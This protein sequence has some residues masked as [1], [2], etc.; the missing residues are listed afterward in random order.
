MAAP[1]EVVRVTPQ[2]ED[3]M[4]PNQII[5]EFNRPVVPLGRMDRRAEEIPVEIS[6]HLDCEWR[7]IDS[8]TLACLLSEERKTKNATRYS[9]VMHPGIRAEDGETISSDRSFSF[10]TSRARVSY[11]WFREWRSPGTPTINLVFTDKV[12]R[13]SAESHLYF[14]ANGKRISSE[15]TQP[16]TYSKDLSFICAPREEL[17]TGASVDL[18]IEPGIEVLEGSEL[19]TDDRTIVKFKTFPEFEVLGVRCRTNEND[20][21]VTFFPGD[22][23]SDELC[24]PLS[25]ISL[26]FNSP[27]MKE[28][29]ISGLSL[30]PSPFSKKPEEDPWSSVYTY[31]RRYGPVAES[32]EYSVWL[33]P[34]LRSAQK[35]VVNIDSSKIKD[36]FGRHPKPIK[37]INIATDHRRPR[38]VVPTEVGT[39]ESDVSTHIP[40]AVQNLHSFDLNYG[41]LTPSGS[42][43]RLQ[44]TIAVD[45]VEDLSYYFPLR[46]RDLLGASSG[47][48]FGTISTPEDIRATGPLVP[49]VISQVSPFAIHLKFGHRNSIAW[50]TSFNTG[51]P[52]KGVQISVYRLNA[53]GTLNEMSGE[54]ARG[55]SD[56]SGIAELPG[57]AELDPEL[58]AADYLTECAHSCSTRKSALLFVAKRGEQMGF[59]SSTSDFEIYPSYSNFT[60]YSHIKSWGMTAQGVY[61]LGDTVQF[62]LFVRDEENKTLVPAPTGKYNLKVVDP[63]DVVV[64]EFS[65]ISLSQFG[66]FSSEF[67]VPEKGAVGIYRFKLTADFS[68][69]TWYPFNVLI[70][71]FTP[72]PFKVS[73]IIANPRTVSIGDTVQLDTQASLYAGGPYSNAGARI[74]ARIQAGKFPEL[75]AELLGFDFDLYKSDYLDQNFQSEAKLDSSGN[76]KTTFAVAPSN[77]L[78]GKLRIESAVRDDRGR[79]IATEEV[80]P[81]AGRERY[82]GLRIKDWLLS[83]GKPATIEGVL[84]DRDC[85]PVKGED[86]EINISREQIKAS[87]VK[88]AGNA[89]LTEYVRE[90]VPVRTCKLTSGEHPISCTFIPDSPGQYK[91]LAS[92]KD[93]KGQIHTTDIGRYA[94]GKGEVVWQTDEGNSLDVVP[95]KSN[96][97]VGDTAKFFVKNPFPG[98][99]ALIS[100]ERTG[101]ISKQVRKLPDSASVIEVPVTEDLIPGFYLSIVVHLPRV[102]RPVE[103]DVDL[104]K[105]LARMGYARIEVND[106]IKQLVVS[107]KARKEEYRPK[108][109]V[110]VDLKIGVPKGARSS[111]PTEV[112]IAVVDESVFDLI[113]EG[114]QAYDASH[115]FYKLG[116]LDLRNF[117]DLVALVGRRKF[118]KKGANS[119]GSGGGGGLEDNLR[120]VKKFVAY[121]NPALSIGPEGKTTFSFSAPDNLTSWKVIAIAATSTDRFGLGTSTLKVNQPLEIRAALPNVVR[122]GDRFSAKFT[123]LNR[124]KEK[125]DA[126]V[127]LEASGALGEKAS[128]SMSVEL[129]PFERKEVELPIITKGDGEVLVDVRAQGGGDFHDRF[130]SKIP[131]LKRTTFE[132]AAAYG[133]TVESN[134]DQTIEFPLDIRTDVGSLD[135]VL[136]SSAISSVEGAFKY[137]RDYPYICWEQ[138]LTKAIMAAHFKAL[139]IYLPDSMIWPESEALPASTLE[140]AGSYQT[141]GGGMSFYGGGDEYADPYLSAYTALGFN[142]LRDIGAKVPEEAERKLH[143]YL[144][145]LL[146]ENVAPSFYSTGMASSVRA[147]ALSALASR[148][149]V[150]LSDVERFKSAL[151][152]MKLFGKA[153]YLQALA[154]LGGDTSDVTKQLLASGNET[155]GKFVFSEILA[156]EDS[157]ILESPLRENCSVLSA[158]LLK[159]EIFEG[160]APKVVQSIIQGRKGKEHW[161]NTQENLFCT[162]AL[163]SYA[164]RYEREKPVM[165][166]K[167]TLSGNE[168]G[169]ASFNDF[170]DPPV[171]LSRAFSSDLPGQRKVL[172]LERKGSGRLYFSNRL[173]Y[174][175]KSPIR[176]GRNAGMEIVR[177]FS[178]ERN[179]KW[180]L[181]KFPMIVHPGELVRVDL[182]AIMPATKNFVVVDDAIPGGFEPVN[183]ELKTSSNVDADKGVFKAAENS[184]YFRYDDWLDY[185]V[186]RWSFYHKELRHDS[187]RFYS[188]YLPAGRYRLSYVAQVIGKGAF[189]VPP[190]KAMEMYNPDTYGLS[191]AGT[192]QVE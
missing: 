117:N 113:R 81:F 115:A 65:N 66:T 49:K 31:S 174:S 173:T 148:G 188:E 143:G 121:W 45:Y 2:G 132:T 34:G 97:K 18:R 36:E 99:E 186:S 85:K 190:A 165:Q 183:R 70:S 83:K 156:D 1:L 62:K 37:P 23:F 39:L 28:D 3:V 189:D 135:V 158:L 133:S 112:A 42:S 120:E 119:G 131:V 102:D 27:V 122:E 140:Q 24:N 160:I 116:E 75:P 128:S 145:K 57:T 12:K 56:S 14:Y 106:S 73:G 51:E 17:P 4:P 134:V 93:Y 10:I 72:A 191:E 5:F 84:L 38:L 47:L 92:V 142:W 108:G 29:L 52:E 40:V 71:D 141:P 150:G 126:T 26:V 111:E 33:P 60:K 54:I 185:G 192:L 157:R 46:I 82:V 178:V 123:L 20:H 147:V 21:D 95:E 15:L 172:S 98:A 61:R 58:E 154:A 8:K 55:L 87:R 63:V 96:Y 90:D 94:L 89:Y 16:E 114:V 104:G 124:T 91:F 6:P 101:T 13:E 50:I 30:S 152:Q 105:P 43:L 144:L 22:Q 79:F 11:Y 155:G 74:T 7:W 182:Y 129:I 68:K 125:R 86:I 179:G 32:G 107:S 138:R 110:T 44:K 77:I 67:Q 59:V 80:L 161:E 151:P 176:T 35:Y 146:R 164:K 137:M 166:I 184:I 41:V 149:A 168:L 187:A 48:L 175:D 163:I 162:R 153:H 64:K 159:N 103:G 100:I 78:Y 139:K 127:N 180:E 25:P 53:D 109:E 171:Q 9:L 88:G 167:A 181:L 169:S 118:E 69:N 130:R 19:S 177:E 76:L 136:S 170:R